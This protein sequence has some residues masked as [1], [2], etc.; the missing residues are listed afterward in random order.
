TEVTGHISPASPASSVQGG[1]DARMNCGL[2]GSQEPLT[3]GLAA[4]ELS[5]EA[6]AMTDALPQPAAPRDT[7]DGAG[8][9]HRTLG[10]LPA[11][12]V[13]MT[14]MCGIGPFITIPLIVAAMGG[15]Q[16][17]LG[18][19]AGAILALAARQGWGGLR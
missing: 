12:A 19:N 5:E 8:R 14:Q 16:A 9:F 6:A 4:V 17:V 3:A 10:V 11:T 2:R 1:C 7:G 15:P 13:N 18:W